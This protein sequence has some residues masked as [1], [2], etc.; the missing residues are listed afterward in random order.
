MKN[1]NKSFARKYRNLGYALAI[2]FYIDLSIG[3]FA[4]VGHDM[5]NRHQIKNDAAAI[6]T[7]PDLST[8][9]ET[10]EAAVEA[11]LADLDRKYNSKN[12]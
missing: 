10:L 5:Y 9:L 2:C 11:D 3:A 4:Y 7:T 1:K 8:G 12:S 6:L